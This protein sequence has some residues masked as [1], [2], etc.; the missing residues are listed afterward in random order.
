MSWKNR[1]KRRG[2]AYFALR[3][4]LEVWLP[5]VLD[6]VGHPAA[7]EVVQETH[8]LVRVRVVDDHNVAHADIAV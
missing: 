2:W 3:E 4:R 5:V 8:K 7:V 1:R 6:V